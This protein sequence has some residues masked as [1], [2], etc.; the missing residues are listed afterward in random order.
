MADAAPNKRPPPT[1]SAAGAKG[2]GKA[3]ISRDNTK[4]RI[5]IG[6][7]VR[8]RDIQSVV[9]DIQKQLTAQLK[10]PPG[11]LITY[12]GQFQNLIDAKQ[13]LMIAVPLALALI[14]MLLF[15]TFGS[16]G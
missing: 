15:F 13:R 6:L 14:F 2:K 9:N 1:K 12:G 3:V 4:R 16:L 7:N 10:L 5:A 8:N 11:Y